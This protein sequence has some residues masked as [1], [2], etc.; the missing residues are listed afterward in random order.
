MQRPTIYM[1]HST[2]PFYSSSTCL[3]LSLT[4]CTSCLDDEHGHILDCKLGNLR[5]L[6]LLHKSYDRVSMHDHWGER[7]GTY[8]HRSALPVVALV[9]LCCGTRQAVIVAE[10]FLQNKP[11][12]ALPCP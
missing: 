4:S 11:S 8:W 12:L 3:W 6:H 10:D 7:V 1:L 9:E 2:L 5:V